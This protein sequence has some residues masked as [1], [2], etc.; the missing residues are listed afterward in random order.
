MKK[1]NLNE[2]NWREELDQL[3]NLPNNDLGKEAA[4]KVWE[5]ATGYFS[6][7]KEDFIDRF[8]VAIYMQIIEPLIKSIKK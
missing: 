3:R 5:L 2:P 7:Y 1:S 8:T 4:S 6:N